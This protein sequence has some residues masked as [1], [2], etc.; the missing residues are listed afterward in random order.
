MQYLFGSDQ[1]RSF[2]Y[3]KN[4][5]IVKGHATQ[6]KLHNSTWETYNHLAKLA[7]VSNE[8]ID[9]GCVFY[10]SIWRKFVIYYA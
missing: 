6:R 10:V 2:L 7:N 3:P 9:F 1:K 8:V 5:S 4:Q